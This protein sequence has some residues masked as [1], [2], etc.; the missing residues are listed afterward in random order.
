MIPAQYPGAVPQTR[1]RRSM[2]TVPVFTM[3]T[4]LQVTASEMAAL[5]AIT[6]VALML[7]WYIRVLIR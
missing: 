2:V 7:A 4:F 5:V 6:A 3:A 1:D